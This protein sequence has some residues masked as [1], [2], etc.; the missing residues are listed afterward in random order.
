MTT[1]INVEKLFKSLRPFGYQSPP[2][3]PPKR[4]TF[5]FDIL[6]DEEESSENG[7]T[8]VKVRKSSL[9]TKNNQGKA[10]VKVV[11]QGGDEWFVERQLLIEKSDYIRT[12]LCSWEPEK[13]TMDMTMLPTLELKAI[14]NFYVKDSTYF[15]DFPWHSHKYKIEHLLEISDFL[16]LEDFL[17][18]CDNYLMSV[19]SLDTYLKVRELCYKFNRW[20]LLDYI[21][22]SWRWY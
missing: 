17:E 13:K 19:L 6:K 14:I 18:A 15:E 3:S 11:F 5:P 9:D 4:K 7:D 20:T 16:L 2:Q 8:N 12:L 1:L 22:Y 21:D 10:L